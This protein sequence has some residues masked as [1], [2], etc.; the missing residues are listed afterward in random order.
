MVRSRSNIAITKPPGNGP[1]LMRNSHFTGHTGPD[2]QK[3]RASPVSRS[4]RCAGLGL[5]VPG[6]WII[7]H[8]RASL[9]PRSIMSPA[10]S[11]KISGPS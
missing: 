11:D 7:P 1:S 8:T 5:V 4:P 10:R 2:E 9:A 3:A 6:D